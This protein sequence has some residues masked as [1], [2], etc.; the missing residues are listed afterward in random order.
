[1]PPNRTVTFHPSTNPAAEQTDIRIIPNTEIHLRNSKTWIPVQI[2]DLVTDHLTHTHNPA[3]SPNPTPPYKDLIHTL[4]FIT[5]YPI[6]GPLISEIQDLLPILH[7]SNKKPNPKTETE[8]E[9]DLWRPFDEMH[10][11]WITLQRQRV[12]AALKSDHLIHQNADT[13]LEARLSRKQPL[14]AALREQ[15]NALALL[16]ARLKAKR[17]EIEVEVEARTIFDWELSGVSEEEEK[18][19]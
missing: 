2:F 8:E 14:P 6:T 5:S 4:S 16:K 3:S 18:K 19:S 13:M 1:M 17:V 9:E 11:Q 7:H 10:K 12:S 15:R